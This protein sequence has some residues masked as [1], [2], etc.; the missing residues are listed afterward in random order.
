LAVNCRGDHARD[1]VGLVDHA[2]EN[3]E[4]DDRGL[5]QDLGHTGIMMMPEGDE[6][7]ERE[8]ALTANRLLRISKMS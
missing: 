8:G 5:V 7:D 6:S 1:I 3:G 4:E 2:V